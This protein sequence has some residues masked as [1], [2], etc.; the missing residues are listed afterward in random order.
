MLLQLYKLLTRIKIN[1]KWI[2]LLKV[3][4]GILEKGLRKQ[5]ESEILSKF[6]MIP[7]FVEQEEIL[8]VHR[9]Y[10]ILFTKYKPSTHSK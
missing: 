10:S 8:D 4:G 9:N 5:V 3:E 2:G 1:F 6:N 7:L